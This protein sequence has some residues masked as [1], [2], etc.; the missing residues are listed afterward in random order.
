MILIVKVLP[1][2]TAKGLGPDAGTKPIVFRTYFYC[3]L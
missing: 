2:F 3:L 1:L